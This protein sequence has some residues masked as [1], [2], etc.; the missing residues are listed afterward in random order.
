MY[1]GSNQQKAGL[2]QTSAAL[3]HGDCR[4]I[5]ACCHRGDRQSASEI[6]V[7]AVRLIG[8][9]VHPCRMRHLHDRTQI[10]TDAV[11]GRVIYQDSNRLGMLL[12][13][14][15]NLFALHSQGYAQPFVRLGIH[16]H[17][18]RAAQ[19]QCIDDAS[20]YISGKNDL[21]AVLTDR[22]HH[23]LHGTGGTSHHQKCMCRAKCIGRQL[24]RLSS[25]RNGVTEVVERFHTVDIH[26][27]TLF[28]QKFRQFRIPLSVLVSRYIEGNDSHLSEA[29]QGFIDRCPPLV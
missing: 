25:D 21:I 4:H 3:V 8:Q 14:F 11:I 12:N 18:N 15:C 7:G 13:R 23:T 19:H 27:H 26:S 5:G 28:S 20:M 29:L 22:K 16:I 9:T 24:L 6:E 10:G 1:S 17:R 2:G